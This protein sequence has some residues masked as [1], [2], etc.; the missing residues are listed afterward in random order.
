[1]PILH[2]ETARSIPRGALRPLAD[3]LGAVFAVPPGH[4]W[5]R[6]VPCDPSLYAENGVEEPAPHVFARLM[7]RR[8]PDEAGL[9]TLAARLTDLLATH[10]GAPR[11]DVH[12]YFEP[13]VAGRI[14]FGGE[15]VPSA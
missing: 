3:A 9:S 11:E 7:L 4:V 8:H 5:V 12:L 15:L 1:M 2:L 6:V 13:P 14:A 10:L